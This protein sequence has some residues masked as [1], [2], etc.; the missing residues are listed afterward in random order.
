MTQNIKKCS[1]RLKIKSFI[2]NLKL[3]IAECI[4]TVSPEE[5]KKLTP[6]EIFLTP[7]NFYTK[8]DAKIVKTDTVATILI[9]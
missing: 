3:P 6:I 8:T 1:F 5:I 7:K 2:F 9:K 4:P